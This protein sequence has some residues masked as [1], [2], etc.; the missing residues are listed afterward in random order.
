MH[1]VSEC[2]YYPLVHICRERQ[3]YSIFAEKDKTAAWGTFKGKFVNK[4]FVARF[5]CLT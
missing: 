3:N 5:Y 4:T 2:V 1:S